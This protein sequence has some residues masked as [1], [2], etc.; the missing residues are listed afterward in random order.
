M[1][2]S[3]TNKTVRGVAWNSIDRI[4]NYGIS[5]L[6]S[7]VLARLLSPED[8]GLIGLINIFIVIFNV[9]LDG[10]LS[11]ALIRKE[12]VSETEY[13]TVFYSNL[14]ISVFLA[15]LLVVCSP[16]IAS[17]FKRLELI[18]LLRV[19]S[20]VLIINS[21][22]I[23]QQTKLT[24]EIQ[25]RLQTKISVISHVGSGVIGIV[26]ALV[27]FGV[28]ALVAQQIS[29]R[30]LATL[31]FWLYGRWMPRLMFSW[32]NFKELFGFGWKLLVSRVINSLWGQLYQAVIGKFY[33][34]YTLGLYTRAIQYAHMF[35]SGV[36]D[37]VLK[38]SLPVMSSIQSEDERLITAARKIIKT[39][40]FVTFVFMMGMA[41]VAK[42]LVFVLIGEKW[43]PCVPMLQIVCFNVMFN[44]LSYINENLL[45]V[46]GRSDKILILQIFKIVL[47]IIPLLLGV[48]IDIYWMLI[49]SAV[50]SW[51]A[52]FLYTYYTNKYFNYSAIQQ[53]R[54]ISPSFGVALIMAVAIYLFNFLP[55]SGY[56][57]LPLQ[58]IV[59]F[60]LVV[61][62]GKIMKLEEYQYVRDVFW[63]LIKK[64]IK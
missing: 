31:L 23:V 22:A 41:A 36:S 44:P 21:L 35:S 24:R 26:L 8:Y 25:F 5:F 45:T 3:L 19:M 27:G 46:K 63:G 18:P 29:S 6:V 33:S 1:A 43:L 64:K 30:L 56:I 16:F 48:F 34:P 59:G 58:I 12:K 37:V 11:T 57:L 10:G 14:I 61:I 53:I 54:D 4:A 47:T 55:V 2:E 15:L 52:I 28:W 32:Y 39:T 50:V 62:I 7:I 17:F 9:I 49:G 42:S 20:L 38:V 51:L 60:G 13:N 40:M